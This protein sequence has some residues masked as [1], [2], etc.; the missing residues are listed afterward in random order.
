MI[1]EILNPQQKI[2]K[3]NLEWQK[4]L[5]SQTFEIA[6]K[7][8]TEKPFSGEY[9]G[10]HKTGDYYCKICNQYLFNSN[11]KFDSKTGWPSY[12]KP[13]NQFSL[14]SRIDFSYGMRREE[15]LCRRCNSH[16]GHVFEDGPE[17]T[18]LR[19]CMNSVVLNFV[20]NGQNLDLVETFLTQ[21]EKEILQKYGIYQKLNNI[22]IMLNK[23]EI[24]LN[25]TKNK[26]EKLKSENSNNQEITETFG[27]YFGNKIIN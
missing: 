9:C 24:D 8:G 26:L 17:P 3:S 4:L 2:T 7:H 25:E 10:L 23:S 14:I 11:S 20:E 6:R 13:A 27:K 1:L 22:L 15:I 18:G 12:Y 5:D 21:K 19:Y 16:L